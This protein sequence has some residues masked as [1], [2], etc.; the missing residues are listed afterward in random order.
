M[1]KLSATL[2]LKSSQLILRKDYR[3]DT[4]RKMSVD[5]DDYTTCCLFSRSCASFSTDMVVTLILS[6]LHTQIIA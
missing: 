4:A 5:I 3:V 1:C 6:I 2:T